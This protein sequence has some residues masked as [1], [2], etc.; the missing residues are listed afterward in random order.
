MPNF[1]P[2]LSQIMLCGKA[3]R[4]GLYRAFDIGKVSL[5]RQ[6]RS[7]HKICLCAG[8]VFW[9]LITG[10]RGERCNCSHSRLYCNRIAPCSRAKPLPGTGNGG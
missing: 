6:F 3:N 5:P 2:G 8:S 7:S 4:S 9:G 10:A 1:I